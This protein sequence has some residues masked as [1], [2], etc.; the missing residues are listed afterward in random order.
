MHT[1]YSKFEW[2][3]VCVTY[4]VYTCMYVGLKNIDVQGAL[5]GKELP[6]EVSVYTYVYACIQSY[7]ISIYYALPSYT[8]YIH[9][10]KIDYYYYYYCYYYY[11]Y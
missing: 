6:I 8:C 7:Y 3:F 11:Y 9:M 5:V 10:L 4:C 2:L 1:Y